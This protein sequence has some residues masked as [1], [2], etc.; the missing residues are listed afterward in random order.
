MRISGIGS[1]NCVSFGTISEAD[2]IQAVK[3]NLT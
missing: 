1:Y 2:K 3:K